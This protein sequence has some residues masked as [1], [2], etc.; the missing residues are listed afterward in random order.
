MRLS[1]C[2][3]GERGARMEWVGSDRSCC[4]CSTDLLSQPRAIGV[5]MVLAEGDRSKLGT[6]TER[7]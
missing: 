5:F 3:A 4:C 7:G 6:S 1:F 2:S